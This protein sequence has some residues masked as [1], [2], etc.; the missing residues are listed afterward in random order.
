MYERVLS[1]SVPIVAQLMQIDGDG[2]AGEGIGGA[3]GGWPMVL[4]GVGRWLRP[5]KLLVCIHLAL[6]HR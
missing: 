1:G 5:L 6:H 4:A 2:D 3:K